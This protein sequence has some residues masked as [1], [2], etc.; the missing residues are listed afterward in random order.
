MNN[1]EFQH[2]PELKDEQALKGVLFYSD[3][4]FIKQQIEGESYLVHSKILALFG[5][6]EKLL[7]EFVAPSQVIHSITSADVELIKSQEQI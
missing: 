5:K 6:D 2:Y 7:Q 4:N 3:G 1:I